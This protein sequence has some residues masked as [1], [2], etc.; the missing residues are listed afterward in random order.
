MK[1]LRYGEAGKERPGLLDADGCIRDLSAH[2]RD[3]RPDMLSPEILTALAA[4]DPGT[5]PLVKGTPRMGV[6]VSGVRKFLAIG[7]NYVDHAK[8]SG[9]AI[10]DEP[11]LFTKAINCLQGPNDDVMLPR[12]SQHSD[13]EVELGIVIGTTARYVSPDEALDH[14]AGYVLVNDV[15]EREYQLRRGGSWD[16]GKGCETFGPVGPWLVTTDELPDPQAISLRLEVNGVRH[17]DGNTANMIFDVKTLVSY[18]SSFMVLEPGDIITTGTP[19]GVGMGLK[20]DPVFLSPGDVMTL[21]SDQ[22][23]SQQQTVIA[24]R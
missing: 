7:L 10:P 12:D 14:V 15:S 24:W 6:P 4:I 19:A 13:W 20:P 2:V 16:K 1:L 18:V 22:L 9:A 17:Q 11:I 8:E 21:Q 5:L 23:G 3:I